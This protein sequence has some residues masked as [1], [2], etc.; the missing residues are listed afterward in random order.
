MHPEPT[1]AS[2]LQ[3]SILLSYRRVDSPPFLSCWNDSERHRFETIAALH[4]PFASV[5]GRHSSLI[6]TPV[7]RYRTYLC[8]E[9]ELSLYRAY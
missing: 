1:T 2:S 7:R 4:D 3:D 5:S 6:H 8:T 9:A